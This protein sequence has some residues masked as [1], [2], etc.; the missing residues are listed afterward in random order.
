MKNKHQ[1]RQERRQLSQARAGD[2]AGADK[3]ISR[4][5]A[6]AKDVPREQLAFSFALMAI[7]RAYTG[8]KEETLAIADSA[9]ELSARF[10]S[11]LLRARVA[12]VV[13]VAESTAGAK[14]RAKASL[15]RL[16]GL[17]DDMESANAPANDLASTLAYLAWAQALS[18]DREGALASTE[19]LKKLIR[20][21]LD[22]YSQ[23][24]QLAAIALVLVKAE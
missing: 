21:R 14:R 13:A 16:K 3:T 15:G 12:A 18:G 10:N 11:E 4:A 24:S 22:S 1:R 9:L 5:V 19:P 8:D 17:Y 23:S 2:K 6:V 20:G 7:A